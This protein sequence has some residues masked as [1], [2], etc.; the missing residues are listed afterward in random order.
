[1]LLKDSS[2]AFVFFSTFDWKKKNQHGLESKLQVDLLLSSPSRWRI[3]NCDP[4][5]HLH[6]HLL[7]G[8]PCYDILHQKIDPG[9]VNKNPKIVSKH[10]GLVIPNSTSVILSELST[11]S[12]TMWRSERGGKKKLT[13]VLNKSNY[14]Q[15]KWLTLNNDSSFMCT[16]VSVI[17]KLKST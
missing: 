4:G 6:D 10:T 11:C 15:T 3:H 1:M 14:K 16:D 5:A 7:R 12:S 9:T 17:R 2:W 13:I 8:C